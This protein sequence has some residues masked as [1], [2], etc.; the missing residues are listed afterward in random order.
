MEEIL[1]LVPAQPFDVDSELIEQR[2]RQV[3]VGSVLEID[4]AANGEIALAA[5]MELVAL[6]V[7]AEVVVVAENEDARVLVGRAV[8]VGR[9]QAA[10]AASHH[11]EVV[12]LVEPSGI[13]PLPALPGSLVGDLV[14]TL[15]IRSQAG[16]PGG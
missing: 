2:E 14:G 7:P 5:V 4:A 3:V 1:V 10:D 15:V 8:E 6:G 16:A 11:D 13:R 9:R 12:G